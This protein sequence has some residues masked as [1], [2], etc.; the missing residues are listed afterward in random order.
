MSEAISA[1]NIERVLEQRLFE[2]TSTVDSQ[3]VSHVAEV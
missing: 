3:D 2:L 1:E